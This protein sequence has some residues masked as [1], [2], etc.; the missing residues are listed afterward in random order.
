MAQC[1]VDDITK[2][3]PDMKTLG[4]EINILA[5]NNK[6]ISKTIEDLTKKISHGI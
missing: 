6:K 2:N 3:R 5:K 4:R 1:K